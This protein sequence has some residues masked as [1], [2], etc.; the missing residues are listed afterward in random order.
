M[1]DPDLALL[2]QSLADLS[3]SLHTA[4]LAAG[5]ASGAIHRRRHTDHGPGQSAPDEVNEAET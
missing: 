1:T 4:A 5:Q 2:A 3:K